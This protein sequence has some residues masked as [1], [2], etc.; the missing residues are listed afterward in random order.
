[1]ASAPLP[2][3]IRFSDCFTGKFWSDKYDFD[4]LKGTLVEFICQIFDLFP[5][6]LYFYG[7]VAKSVEGSFFHIWHKPNLVNIFLDDHHLGY[8][9][10]GKKKGLH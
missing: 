8:I 4:I 3:L 5:R 1:M 6:T 2:K 9:T 10:I 7:K